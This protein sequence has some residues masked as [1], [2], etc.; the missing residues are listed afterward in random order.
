MTVARGL[1]SL[2]FFLLFAAL[3]TCS[4]LSGT[5]TSHFEQ[6][7]FAIISCSYAHCGCTTKV[8][9]SALD[10]H[11][12]AES[13]NHSLLLLGVVTALQVIAFHFLIFGPF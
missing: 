8:R 3:L 13:F 12:R 10:E 4:V 11:L 9:R 1:F 6:C 2:L 5:M 7:T